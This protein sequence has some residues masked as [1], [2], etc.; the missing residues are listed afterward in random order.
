MTSATCGSW[1]GALT[2]RVIRHGCVL[3][4]RPLRALGLAA[5]VGAAVE[6]PAGRALVDRAGA[7][8]DRLAQA[9]GVAAGVCDLVGERRAVDAAVGQPAATARRC[10]S[11]RPRG[12]VACRRGGR[13]RRAAPA[14]RRR[15]RVARAGRRG[16]RA[17]AC[18]SASA[19]EPALGRRRRQR[20]GFAGPAS[21]SA[22]RRSRRRRM[23]PRR[24][25]PRG[26]WTR[27]RR[28]R[29][30]RAGR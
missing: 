23:S 16:R 26:R 24:L 9:G 28:R 21:A 7:E 20:R 8:R 14:G 3:T 1:I 13:P 10:P 18:S 25:H 12:A 19:S 15:A 5:G 30:G 11:R 6:A 22:W 17:I 29:P 4:G 2:W 27:R